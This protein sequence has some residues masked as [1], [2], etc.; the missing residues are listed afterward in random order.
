VLAQLADR[1]APEDVPAREQ[2]R[3][4]ALDGKTVRG[5]RLPTSTSTSTSTGSSGGFR[6][7]HLVSVLDQAS[8]AVLG[9]VGVEEKSSEVAAFTTLLDTLDLTEVLITADAVHTNRSHAD[10]L[11][12]RGGHYVLC[13]KLNQPTLLR[14]LR[15]LPWT[16]IGVAARERGRGHGRVETR[17]ISVVSLHPCPDLGGEFFPH[18]AQV[19]EPA[20]DRSAPDRAM[21]WCWNRR[22]RARRTQPQ[23]AMRPPP[24]VV[25]GV[26]GK[27][28]TQV[29]LTEDQHAVGDLGP[30]SQDE[31]F[32]E[33]VRPWAPRRDLD[34]LD[35]R[36]RQHRVE[37]CRELA[38]SVAH[39]EPKARDLLAEVHD[40]VAGLL[41]RPWPVGVAGDGQDVQVAATDFDDEEHVEP[42][43]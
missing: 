26:Y 22:C 7:P 40:E 30:A 9:Q 8:G 38:G 5:A 39:E 20:Q 10:Y 17:T 24:V 32:G 29:S 41:C 14:R 19:E 6:Q 43:Q 18:A 3:V 42:P 36:V 33:A 34:H 31:A 11:H 28:G 4:L 15:A 21:V 16:Q 25:L 1:P 37:R 27:H 23:R 12:D 2:R 13:A 35:A